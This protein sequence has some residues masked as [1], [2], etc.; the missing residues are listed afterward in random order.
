MV[1]EDKLVEKSLF[2]SKTH[3]EHTYFSDEFL[4]VLSKLTV[5]ILFP[6]YLLFT[7]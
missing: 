1:R 4:E 2:I 3:Q 7:T 5:L 6:Y